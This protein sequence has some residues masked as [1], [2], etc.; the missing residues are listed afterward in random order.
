MAK[1]MITIAMMLVIR[2]VMIA[3]NAEDVLADSQSL[4]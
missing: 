3:V 2:P 1:K 4:S